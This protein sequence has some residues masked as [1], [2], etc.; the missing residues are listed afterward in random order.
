MN[1]IVAYCGWTKSISHHF[2]SRLLAFTG[3]SSETRLLSGG[4]GFRP[5]T[6]LVTPMQLIDS[7]SDDSPLNPG[8]LPIIKLG[9][10]NMGSTLM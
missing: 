4:A 6:V 9:L 8:T 2:E 10:M 1:E 3:E 5:S 7:K